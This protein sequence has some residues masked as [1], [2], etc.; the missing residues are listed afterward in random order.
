MGPLSEITYAFNQVSTQLALVGLRVKISK[1]KLWNPSRISPSIKIPQGYTLV[2]DG[3]HILVVLVGSQN[4]ATHF[5]D[6]VLFQNMAH[7]NN[8]FLLGDTQVALGILSSC[9]TRRPSY[10]TLTVPPSSF[11]SFITFRQESYASMWGHYGSR[12]MGVFSGPLNEALGSTIDILWWYKPSFYG[13]LSP[14]YFSRELDFSGSIF[15][16]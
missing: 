2:T 6:E 5:L 4:F 16:L 3:L 8:F 15:V 10:L 11:F 7:T 12:I 9:I 1:C 14:I 13:G